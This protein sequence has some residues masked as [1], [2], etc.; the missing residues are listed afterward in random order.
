MV[1]GVIRY[2]IMSR[3]SDVLGIGHSDKATQDFL[4]GIRDDLIKTNRGAIIYY[5]RPLEPS[6]IVPFKRAGMI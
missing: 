2:D 1:L 5:L 3:E 6:E 4:I